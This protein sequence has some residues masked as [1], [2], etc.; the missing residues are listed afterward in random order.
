MQNTTNYSRYA[1]VLNIGLD[2]NPLRLLGDQ[3]R[4]VELARLIAFHLQKS[5]GFGLVPNAVL[6]TT[7][8]TPETNDVT[9]ESTLVAGFDIQARAFNRSEQSIYDDLKNA[10]HALSDAMSQDAIAFTFADIGEAGTH[11]G[12]G[13]AGPRIEAWGEFDAAMFL[14]LAHQPDAVRFPV[15]VG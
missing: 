4:E 7:V 2:N 11:R 1:V 6:L 9:T 8:W 12:Q 15:L 13:L 14:R 5:G 3:E 10:I